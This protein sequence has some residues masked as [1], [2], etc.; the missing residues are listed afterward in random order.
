MRAVVVLGG[1][2]VG[3]AGEETL[4]AVITRAP[5]NLA[6]LHDRSLLDYAHSFPSGHVTAVSTL[7]GMIACVP[8]RDAARR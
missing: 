8:G 2:G 1:V 3:V 6:E 5:A 4:K 7:L